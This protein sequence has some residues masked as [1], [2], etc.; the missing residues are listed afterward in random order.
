MAMHTQTKTLLRPKR[1]RI[2][3]SIGFVCIL[4]AGLGLWGLNTGPDNLE[5]GPFAENT[6][7]TVTTTA[8]P[9]QVVLSTLVNAGTSYNFH[10]APGWYNYSFSG[11]TPTVVSPGA[12]EACMSSTGTVE[13]SDTNTWTALNGNCGGL[14]EAP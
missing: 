14:L 12:V 10:L 11:P 8:N 9:A 13:T 1:N 4:A 7:L 5:V 3:F 2:L 6:T